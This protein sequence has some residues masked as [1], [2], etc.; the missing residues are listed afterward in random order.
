MLSHR[1]FPGDEPASPGVC[2]LGY[3]LDDILAAC[4]ERIDPRRSEE[5]L[6]RTVRIA[7]MFEN[8]LRPAQPVWMQN[9]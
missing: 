1:N 7:P 9:A 5:H 2:Y 4:I 8:E 6:S 3:N